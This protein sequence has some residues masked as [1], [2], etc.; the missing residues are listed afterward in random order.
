[1]MFEDLKRE[2]RL[3]R[4]DAKPHSNPSRPDLQKPPGA[5]PHSGFRPL[6]GKKVKKDKVSC[7]QLCLRIRARG[8]ARTR[9]LEVFLMCK[10]HWDDVR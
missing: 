5:T 10:S 7:F 9:D 3:G 1:M 2:K 4:V 6:H 8:G